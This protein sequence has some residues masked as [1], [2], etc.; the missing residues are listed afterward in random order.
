M[1]EPA[2]G[3]FGAGL[4]ARVPLSGRPGVG[5]S[6][7]IAARVRVPGAAPVEAFAVHPR[8]PLRR[9]NMAAWREG[10]RALP[11]AAPDGPLRILAGDFNATL[12][13]AE[14][15]RVLDRG[16][17]DGAAEVGAGLRAT[18]P[19]G[20]RFPPPV[21]IDR[22][23]ADARVGWREVRVHAVPRSDHRAVLAEIVLPRR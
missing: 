1:A 23:V 2:E 12:D 21:T 4:Y 20:R 6:A 13:N 11:P 15:R 10:L 14:L 17:E 18:W 3:A 22:V 7:P 9:A 19:A 5:R 8:A 16:Y